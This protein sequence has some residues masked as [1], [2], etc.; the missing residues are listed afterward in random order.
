LVDRLGRGGEPALENLECEADVVAA[1]VAFGQAIS[2]VHLVTHIVG[3][4]LIQRRLIGRE[5]VV[6]GVGPPLGEQR[7]AVEGAPFLLG[8]AAQQVDRVGLVDALAKA[9]LE[10]IAVEQCHEQL[11]SASLPLCGVAVISRKWRQRPDR[12][13]PSW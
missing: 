2:T 6:D 10:P 4:G 3:H 7:P 1:L 5:L 11:E 12:R 13:W 9:P 8:Q